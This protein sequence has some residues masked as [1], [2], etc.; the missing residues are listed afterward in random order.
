MISSFDTTY[1]YYLIPPITVPIDQQF[2]SCQSLEG[3]ASNIHT[4]L[5]PECFTNDMCNGI[6]CKFTV[7]G[8]MFQLETLLLSCNNPPA[9]ETVLEDEN[10][11]P[12]STN[13]ASR[14]G[15]YYMRVNTLELPMYVEITHYN[16]SMDISV[17]FILMQHLHVVK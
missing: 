11:A 14:T 1:L 9:I 13:T 10:N 12:L 5:E 15:I 16:Y 3:L 2:C 17:S 6:R 8:S 7:L 4:P